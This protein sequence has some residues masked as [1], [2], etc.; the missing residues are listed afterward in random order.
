MA[1][2]LRAIAQIVGG[3]KLGAQIREED[4]QREKLD[5]AKAKEQFDRL[6]KKTQRK[7]EM[8]QTLLTSDAISLPD[9]QKI[10]QT[11]QREVG[12]GFED[13]KIQPPAPKLTAFEEDRVSLLRDTLRDETVPEATR[14]A[15]RSSLDAVAAG[16][17]SVL[18][19]LPVGIDQIN[20]TTSST[21]REVGGSVIT[22]V[23]PDGEQ[24]D[25]NQ[26]DPRLP[27]L[28]DAGFRK[29]QDDKRPSGTVITLAR[30]TDEVISVQ[31]D[32][33][34]VKDL[35][36]QGFVKV[37]RGT[38]LEVGAD[39]TVRFRT[40]VGSNTVGTATAAQIRLKEFERIALEIADLGK[41]ITT[42]TVGLR[43][44][45]GNRILD[46]LIG[47]DFANADRVV[48]RQ[49]M[50][51]VKE[52]ALKIMSS[53][54]RFSIP[55]RVAIERLFPGKE[56]FAGS[57]FESAASARAKVR[58]LVQIMKDRAAIDANQLGRKSIVNMTPHEIRE[59]VQDGL[60]DMQV[61]T[62]IL[63]ALHGFPLQA[64]QEQ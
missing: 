34:K 47:G 14:Q 8:A 17:F 4:F 44:F 50:L 37:T 51:A 42:E 46:E 1:S 30:G 15:A 62:R 26:D 43:G 49:K 9:K 24:R 33:P 12:G 18:K 56:N 32:D 19:T 23:S 25:I 7:L 28:L 29:V 5:F 54:D 64:E 61:A 38:D 3:P 6:D 10:L 52:S 48:A 60:L 53:D 16:D 2:G 20:A 31:Q 13:I 59:A 58:T 35:L 41:V 36:D 40:N 27:R 21:N 11:I 63:H 45:L 22:V 55:D 39:G 57:A